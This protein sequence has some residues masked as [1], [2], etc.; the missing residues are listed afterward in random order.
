M[1]NNVIVRIGKSDYTTEV[2]IGKHLLVAD[3]PNELGGQDL[4]PTPLTILLSSLGTCKAI[5]MRMYANQ[6]NWPLE[7]IVLSLSAEIKK[8]GIQ[9]QTFISCAIE[10]KGNLDDIQKERISK[11]ADKCPIQKMLSNPIHIESKIIS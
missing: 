7:G 2:S 11:I 5:T 3:E 8:E 1:E 9:Q 10:L 6:K 4:G